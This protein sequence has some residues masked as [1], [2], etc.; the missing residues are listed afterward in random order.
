MGRPAR[1]ALPC[2]S[3]HIPGRTESVG[4]VDVFQLALQNLPVAAVEA[5]GPRDD[6]MLK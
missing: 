6:E 1:D 4:T 3:N 2:S 5:P